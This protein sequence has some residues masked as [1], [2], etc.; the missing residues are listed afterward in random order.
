MK[1]AEIGRGQVGGHV[2]AMSRRRD[3]SR[4]QTAGAAPQTLTFAQ[5]VALAEEHLTAGRLAAAEDLCRRILAA[6]AAHAPALHLLGIVALRAGNT[7]GAID[8]VRR[9]C[10][11]D[12][13][14]ALFFCNLCELCRLG[15]RLDDALAAGR[16]ALALRT[17]YPEALNNLGIVYFERGELEAAAAHYRRALALAPGYAEVHNNL[18]NVL[19]SQRKLDE[20]LAAYRQALALKPA[21]ADAINNMGTTLRDLGRVAEAESAY[22]QALVLK[23]DDLTTLLNLALSLKDLER[24]DAAVAATER[25]LA[26]AP[27][28][29]KALTYLALIR[30]DQR[31]PADA[32]APCAQALALSPNDADALNSMG[33]IRQEQGQLDEA[34]DFFRRAIAAKPGLAD[35]HNNLGNLLRE[36]GDLDEARDAFAR[37]IELNPHEAGYF[38]NL[39]DA[40]TFVA[41]D[42]DLAAMESLARDIGGL[43][44]LPALRLNFALAKA[45]DDL[46]RF[47]DAF[48]HMQ[49][50]NRRQR[51]RISY[52]EAATFALFDRVREVFTGERIVDAAG[53][54]DPSEVPIFV[55]GMPR[56]GTTLVEQILASHPQVHGAGELHDFEDAVVAAGSSAGTS[57]PDLAAQLPTGRVRRIGAAYVKRLRRHSA[58]AARITDK[59]PSNYFFIGLIHLALPHA[60]IVHVMRDP[61]ETCF[62][63]YSKLF[64]GELSH[65]YDLAELGRYYR[66]YAELMAHWRAVLPRGRMLEI[67]YEDVVTD[68]DAAARALIAHCGLPWDARCLAFHQHRRPVKTASASQVRRP[69]YR[70]S[71]TRSQAYR[72]HLAPLLEALGDLAPGAADLRTSS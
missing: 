35:A 8:F 32:A 62:S 65:T 6:D 67:S 19:R 70:S 9:A 34:L 7:P 43:A 66:K 51:G 53:E 50:G 71:Q 31:R 15:G 63:C 40:K 36:Q 47:D 17:D 18:G 52:E 16:R 60:R 54:G 61:V 44:P 2:G 56:S 26:L 38:V 46:G 55:L 58:G 72:G 33:R 39:A 3:R 29:A 68:L 41:G 42:A 22:R 24:F 12:P 4:P 28:S 11:A 21:Y 14:A 23:P 37:A 49:D 69:I 1:L 20:A 5:A 25:A 48:R 64:T 30:L 59:M 57:F 27:A 10:E 13:H 45:H